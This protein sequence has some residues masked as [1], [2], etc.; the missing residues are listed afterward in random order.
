MAAGIEGAYG[1]GI[2][3]V[4]VLMNVIVIAAIFYFGARKG[5]VASLKSRSEGVREKLMESKTEL[6]KVEL[7]LNTAKSELKDFESTRKRML[8]DIQSEAEQLSRTILEGASVTA[9]RILQ[10]AKLAAKSEARGAV[11]DLKKALVTQAVV[12]TQQ[13]LAQ[14][15]DQQS[16][17]HTQLFEL[18][19]NDMKGAQGHGR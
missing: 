6:A 18:L 13:I 19:N 7:A 2:K 1:P 4:V 15:K 14:S 3:E 12:E 11:N 8:I 17:V 9:E 16:T 10:D 5:I